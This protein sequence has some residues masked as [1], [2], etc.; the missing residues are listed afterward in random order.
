VRRA[1]AD[2]LERPLRLTAGAQAD[3]GTQPQLMRPSYDEV[4]FVREGRGLWSVD[5]EDFEAG[6]G[7]NLT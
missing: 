4:Q 2:R 6:A 7:E 3:P 1:T 5:G